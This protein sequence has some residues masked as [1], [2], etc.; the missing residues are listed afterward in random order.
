MD[1]FWLGKA[2]KYI[3]GHNA[4][5][6]V[7]EIIEDD[8]GK[9]TTITATVSVNLP[10]KF[11]SAGITDIGVKNKEDVEFVF[12]DSFPLK[13]PTIY[14]RDDF[15]KSFPHINPSLKRVK[16]CI[17]EGDLSELLQQ[18][19]WMY[20]ILNQLVDWL[21][22]AASDDLLNYEQGWE[23]MRN[24]YHIGWLPYEIDDVLSVYK[25]SNSPYLHREVYYEERKGKILTDSLCN[26]DKK[27][28]AHA[29]YAI[30]PGVVNRYVPNTITNLGHLY[31]YA[32][33]IGIQDL[34]GNIEEI[35]LSN[36]DEDLLFIVLSVKRPVNIIGT[37][38]DVEFLNFVIHKSKHRLK[39]RRELKRTLPECKV[40]MMSHISERSPALLKR[41]SGTNTKL[42]EKKN[43][44]LVGCGSLGSKIGIHLARNGNGP[45]LCI[46]DDVFMPHNNARHALSM[47]WAQNKAELVA[48]SMFSIGRIYAEPDKG[49]VFDTDFGNSR[50]IIDTT[51]SFS[52]RNFLMSRKDFP[53]IISCGLYNNGRYGLLVSENKD[54]TTRLTE[55]W[56]YLYYKALVDA[57][58]QRTLFSSELE[59]VRIGQSCS[60][61]TMTIDDARI[62]LIASTMS[63]KIQKS[64]EMNL[65]DNAEIMFLK[66][67]GNYSLNSQI[68]PVPDFIEISSKQEWKA[69]ISKPMI[70]QMRELMQSKAPN[71][72]GGALLGSVFLYPKTIIITGIIKAPA[73][74]IES[75]NLFILG[76]DGLEKRIKETEKKT[77]GKVT[78]LGTWHSHPYGGRASKVDNRTYERLLF[79]RNYEP[80]V[81]LIITHHDVIMV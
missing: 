38:S 57:E 26:P 25:K 49:K 8:S 78:Y 2:H 31:E 79:V 39:K 63:I 76:V 30:T 40:G 60:S 10:S 68:F 4:F 42:N 44:A 64:L 46:D 47:A 56:G 45:F 62:S 65:A 58:L 77:N 34:K 73:D 12:P 21:E 5:R 3:I 67:D 28:K 15:P 69:D 74:S 59:N 48:L 16:P 1:N 71:E 61:Q 72:T 6:D 55:I 24:D 20:G 50:V 43:I 75:P 23:P 7:S 19:E 22:K 18:S 13:A 66:Y 80:T 32:R 54:T 17:Y 33:S 36:V 51:A 41:I 35:D 9:K 37:D 70:D 27:K 29:L 52:V 53:P 81:C 14:L 11:I